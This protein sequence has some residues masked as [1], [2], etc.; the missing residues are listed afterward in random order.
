MSWI[1]IIVLAVGT[2]ALRFAGPVLRSRITVSATGRRLRCVWSFA[3]S[4]RVAPIGS[5]CAGRLAGTRNGCS[6]RP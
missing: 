1:A 2:Y 5:R 6:A 3:S 4:A